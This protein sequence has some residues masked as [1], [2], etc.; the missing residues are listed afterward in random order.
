MGIEYEVFEEFSG[1]TSNNF[2]L[3]KK[4]EILKKLQSSLPS[5]KNINFRLFGVSLATLNLI[6]STFIAV[7]CVLVL[8]NEKNK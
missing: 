7:F 4:E 5:C 3:I 2:D 8:K 1:C 6:I